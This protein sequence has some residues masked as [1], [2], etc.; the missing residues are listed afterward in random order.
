MQTFLVSI[1]LKVLILH[2]KYTIF[3]TCSALICATGL[4]VQSL[5]WGLCLETD[6]GAKGIQGWNNES[7][8]VMLQSVQFLNNCICDRDNVVSLQHAKKSIPRV[9]SGPSKPH[10]ENLKLSVK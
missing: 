9:R 2:Q 8:S 3:T 5:A 10:F 1:V 7:L 6:S 4:N